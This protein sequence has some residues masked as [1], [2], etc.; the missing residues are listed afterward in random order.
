MMYVRPLF[1]VAS[2]LLGY[3]HGPI[4]HPIVYALPVVPGIIHGNDRGRVDSPATP[5]FRLVRY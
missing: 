4:E 1:H 5:G 3:H 2:T